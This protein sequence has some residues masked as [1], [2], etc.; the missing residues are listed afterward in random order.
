MQLKHIKGRIELLTGTTIG[1]QGNIEIGGNDNPT[2]RNPLTG[3]VYI[4]GSSIKGKMR[5]LAEWYV[6]G[7]EGIN[8]QGGNVHSCKSSQCKIC[9]MFGRSAS[10]SVEQGIGPT[11]LIVRDAFLTETSR[12]KLSKLKQTK[13]FDTEMKYENNIN[14]LNSR[15]NPRNIERIPSGV[16]FEFSMSYKVLDE[17]DNKNFELLLDFLRLV[18]L[19]GI[20]GGI[21]RGNGQVK[22]HISVD[23]EE[24]N[25]EDRKV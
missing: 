13:G 8:E 23:G 17:E 3:E 1:S 15:A 14:R 22:F 9:R 2:V 24:I 4:P 7:F 10:D 20:G 25:L 16:E 5:S 18:E 19:D 12:K 11:R 21:S 6:L